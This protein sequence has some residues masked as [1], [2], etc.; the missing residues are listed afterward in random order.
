MALDKEKI[1][2]QIH[3][4]R[5]NISAVAKALQRSRNTIYLFMRDNPEV[6]QALDDE[7]EILIDGIENKFYEQ[8]LE[9]NTTSMIFF[10]KTQGKN[11][12]WI[13]KREHEITGKDSGPIVVVNWDDNT[14]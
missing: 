14:D 9:G 11:R 12:G 8:C 5:G 13:E 2:K 7:R 6:K 3:K 10:L 1:I 4:Y